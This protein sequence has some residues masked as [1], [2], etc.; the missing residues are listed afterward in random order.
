MMEA[1]CY[2]EIMTNSSWSTSSDIPEASPE[3]GEYGH[4][5]PL[6]LPRG[7]PLS[8]KVGTN[9]AVKRRSLSL[10]SSLEGLGHGVIIII[11]IKRTENFIV[12]SIAVVW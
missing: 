6:H 11:I 1:E 8:S 5:D 3:S 7:S 10:Y 4:M 12:S 2:R 9:L